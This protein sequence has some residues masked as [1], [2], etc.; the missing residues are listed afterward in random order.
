MRGEGVSCHKVGA[1]SVVLGSL[2]FFI[3]M[4]GVMHD[5]ALLTMHDSPP[6]VY[7]SVNHSAGRCVCVCM[8]LCGTRSTLDI[9]LRA[10]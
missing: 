9:V 8:I 5:T 7:C 3:C 2:H 1:D 4:I 6:L 10:L